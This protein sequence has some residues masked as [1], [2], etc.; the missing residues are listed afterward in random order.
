MN[1]KFQERSKVILF[2]VT[3]SLISFHSYSYA[4]LIGHYSTTGQVGMSLD[5]LG[6]V[7]GIGNLDSSIPLNSSIE[8]AFLYAAARSGGSW[9]S[10]P[11]ITFG[12][13]VYNSATLFGSNRSA[14]FDVST[15]VQNQ[16]NPSLVSQTWGIVENT[17]SEGT[18]LAVVYSNPSLSEGGILL[19]TGEGLNS[20]YSAS[21]PS[22]I[23]LSSGS[24]LMSLGISYSVDNSSTQRTEVDVNG[25]R[26]SNSAGGNGDGFRSNGA[27]LEIGGIGDNPA[28]PSLLDTNTDAD[29]LLYTL[30]SFVSSGD[31]SIDFVF[32]GISNDDYIFFQGIEY[33]SLQVAIVPEPTTALALLGLVTSA[34]FRRRRRVLR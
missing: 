13:D 16:Y 3:A 21:L 28:N 32:N 29:D 17:D 31:S 10:S 34:F 9:A 2:T 7:T 19:S 6:T 15:T 26:L 8:A 4:S 27:L 1:L 20:T 25:S 22:T 23:D 33:T 18:A 11:T 30:D 12:G 14:V 5:G 24:V